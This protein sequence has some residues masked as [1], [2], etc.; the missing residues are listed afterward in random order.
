MPLRARMLAFFELDKLL[1]FVD[2]TE[3]CSSKISSKEVYSNGWA[4]SSGFSDSKVERS[5]GET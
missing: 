5:I 2:D 4:V 3:S 1:Y